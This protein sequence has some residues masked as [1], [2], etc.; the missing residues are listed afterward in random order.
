VSDSALQTAREKAESL[1]GVD[2]GP[3]F[4]DYGVSYM[5]G[6]VVKRILLAGIPALAVNEGDDYVPGFFIEDEDLEELEADEE[7]QP[8]SEQLALIREANEYDGLS[9]VVLIMSFLGYGIEGFKYDPVKID[10]IV[11]TYGA[12]LN[13]FGYGLF[14]P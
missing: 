11:G 14:Q 9:I 6:D 4:S 8:Y 10:T 2:L 13:G 3:L 5:A 1:T 12:P 7:L